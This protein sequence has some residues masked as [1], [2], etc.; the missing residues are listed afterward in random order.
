MP[1]TAKVYG[2]AQQCLANKEIDFDTDTVK[3]ILCT[4]AYTPNQDTHRYRSSVTNEVA[5]G[6][7]Y[8][9]GGQTLAGKTV[10]YDTATNTLKLTADNVSWPSSTITARYAVFFVDTGTAGTSPLLCYW[11]FGEDLASSAGPFNLNMNAAGLL[12]LVTA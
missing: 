1:V 12:T 5:N 4:S 3:V 10:T 9:T 8:T 2:L 11:D 7:G 6:N